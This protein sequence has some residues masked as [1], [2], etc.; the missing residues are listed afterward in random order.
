[1]TTVAILVS[2]DELTCIF[3]SSWT[4]KNLN[5]Y[6]AYK[7]KPYMNLHLFSYYEFE[8]GYSPLDG[9][10]SPSC[11]QQEVQALLQQQTSQIKMQKASLSGIR[12][13]EELSEC[14]PGMEL[15]EMLAGKLTEKSIFYNTVT[16]SSYI[17]KSTIY[18]INISP[19]KFI[20]TRINLHK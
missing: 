12:T 3:G 9:R 1:M 6:V 7:I 4:Q 2:I 19:E 16:G 20:L 5:D 11:L 17:D 10:F 8:Q 15:L 14:R 18:L 13:L